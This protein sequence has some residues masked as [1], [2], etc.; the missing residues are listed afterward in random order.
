MFGQEEDAL[1][2]KWSLLLVL[3]VVVAVLLSACEDAATPTPV[4]TPTPTLADAPRAGSDA[5]QMGMR[6][7]GD[8]IAGAEITLFLTGPGGNPATRARVTVNGETATPDDEGR[9]V[10]SVPVDATVLVIEA[11]QG[12]AEGR[13]EVHVLPA[14]GT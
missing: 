4:P 6:L 11:A 10:I 1:V 14:P 13:L 7:E 9:V 8:P 12:R 5:P 3:M 2:N